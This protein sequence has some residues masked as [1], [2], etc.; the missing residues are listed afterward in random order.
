MF[1]FP[2]FFY[3]NDGDGSFSEVGKELG[4]QGNGCALASLA[5][6]KDGI[7][8]IYVANDYGAWSIQMNILNTILLRRNLKRY[9][10]N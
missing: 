6:L 5:F 4:L 3:Q 9:R 8:S 10:M 7:P 2:N 1:A